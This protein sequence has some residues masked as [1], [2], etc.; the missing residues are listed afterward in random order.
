MN[1]IWDW[2]SMYFG[3]LIMYWNVLLKISVGTNTRLYDGYIKYIKYML[4]R[5]VRNSPINPHGRETNTHK[6][7]RVTR[8]YRATDLG[9]MMSSLRKSLFLFPTFNPKERSKDWKSLLP[10]RIT[11]P[12]S[13]TR[14]S[15]LFL[16]PW[17]HHRHNRR[18]SIQPTSHLQIAPSP[19]IQPPK[20]RHRLFIWNS[21]ML[22]DELQQPADRGHRIPP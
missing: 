1:R 19:R 2:G 7:L 21:A 18:R 15:T 20:M 11:I 22:P 13:R 14:E 4:L 8:A 17:P 3:R 9:P 6:V 10:F 16:P 12:L 5:E